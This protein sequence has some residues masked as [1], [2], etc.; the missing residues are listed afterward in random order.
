MAWFILLI[1]LSIGCKAYRPDREDQY[2]L[3]SAKSVD[4]VNSD[5]FISELKSGLEQVQLDAE[6]LSDIVVRPS[7]EHSLFI[8]K[9]CRM[10][11]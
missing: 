5:Q 9:E 6:L 4:F 8:P 7:K 3:E 11:T 2:L 1:S 10:S